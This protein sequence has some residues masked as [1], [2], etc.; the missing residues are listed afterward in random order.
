[1]GITCW[2]GGVAWGVCPVGGACP[3]LLSTTGMLGDVLLWWGLNESCQSTAFLF[4]THTLLIPPQPVKTDRETNTRVTRRL[5]RLVP[6]AVQ[7][8]VG[9][10]QTSTG[11]FL[12]IYRPSQRLK[13]ELGTAELCKTVVLCHAKVELLPLNWVIL[14]FIRECKFIN[15]N[16]CICLN[17]A[18]DCGVKWRGRHYSC[19]VV[20]LQQPN[21]WSPQEK[22]WKTWLTFRPFPVW[23]NYDGLF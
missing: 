18:W 4:N 2:L 10:V 7:T 6:Y 1:M 8:H 17:R 3:P 13:R 9:S 15:T 16:H 19:W 20:E 11:W 12:L 21:S 22:M 5:H 14:Y 23:R